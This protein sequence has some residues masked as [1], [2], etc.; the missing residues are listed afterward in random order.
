VDAFS[1]VLKPWGKWRFII[2]YDGSSPNADFRDSKLRSF[3]RRVM[4]RYADAFVANSYGAK[5]YL[6]E[7][8]G[9]KPESVFTRTYLVPDAKTLQQSLEKNESKDLTAKASSFSVCWTHYTQKRSQNPLRSLLDSTISRISK[10]T[11][12]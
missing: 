9:A 7:G 6:I 2:I 3:F 12:S 1:A 8:V 4:S 10:I 5:D 11:R